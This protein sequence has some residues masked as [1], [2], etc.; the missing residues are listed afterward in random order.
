MIG[1]IITVGFFIY[2]Y[3][4]S[5][6]HKRDGTA[7]DKVGAIILFA[8]GVAL[9]WNTYQID[10]AAIQALQADLRPVI[11]RSDVLAYKQNELAEALKN[12]RVRTLYFSSH[13]NIAQNISGYIVAENLKYEF[14]LIPASITNNQIVCWTGNALKR[15]GNVGDSENTRTGFCAYI[16]PSSTKT[17]ELDG[18]YL[19][20]SDIEGRNYCYTERWDSGYLIPLNTKC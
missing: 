11:E 17:T 6:K 19:R 14:R 10:R 4:Y 2:W 18:I 13:K 8:T 12:N 20:Y 7:R 16:Q 5:P 15:L 3:L 9:L 1:F